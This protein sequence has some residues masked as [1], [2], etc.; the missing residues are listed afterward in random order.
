MLPCRGRGR[1][2]PC[3]SSPDRVVIEQAARSRDLSLDLVRVICLLGVVMAH[4]C[5]VAIRSTP[6]GGMQNWTPPQELWFFAAGTWVIQPMPLFFVIGGCVGALAWR[7]AERR[8]QDAWCFA[9]VRLIRFAQPAAGLFVLL[10]LGFGVCV[11]AGMPLDLAH[12]AAFGIGN[13]IWFMGAY[14]L[15]QTMLPL[16]VRAHRARPVLTLVVLA[17]AAVV[18]DLIRIWSGVDAVGLA[19]YLFVWPFAQQLG[20]ALAEGHWALNR[21]RITAARTRP[22][23]VLG[24]LAATVVTGLGASMAPYGADLLRNQI[25]PTAPILSLALAHTCLFLLVRPLLLKLVRRRWVQAIMLL[26]GTRAMTIYLWH[27]VVVIGIAALFFFIPGLPQAP[28]PGWWLSRIPVFLVAV[29]AVCVISVPLSR[30]ER[31]AA[32]T[33][34]TDSSGSRV[35]TVLAGMLAVAPA[36]LTTVPNGEGGAIGLNLWTLLGSA[37]VLVA[38]VVLLRRGR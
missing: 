8:G 36:F 21:E 9:R 25:P 2:D 13:P 18:V 10:G 22:W 34:D 14:L 37:V 12:S 28:S 27:V 32:P 35:V 33:T 26:I 1:Y 38:A 16:M 17:G 15:C 19:N 7:K 31:V 23:L 6:D 4:V 11:L 29:A 24:W 5:F 30:L 3:M 20:I